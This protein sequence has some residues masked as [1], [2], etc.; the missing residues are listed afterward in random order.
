MRPARSIRRAPNPP[1]AGEG[2]QEDASRLAPRTYRQTS[3]DDGIPSSPMD[4]V[5]PALGTEGG[6]FAWDTERTQRMKMMEVQREKEGQ[7]G[8]LRNV[9]DMFARSSEK[10]EVKEERRVK[11]T[12]EGR[13]EELLIGN[14]NGE[15]GDVDSVLRKIQRDWPF[16]LDPE[17]APTSLALSLLSSSSTQTSHPPLR[18]F[19]TLHSTLSTALQRS[20]QRHYETYASSLPEHARL[21]EA[22]GRAQGLVKDTKKLLVVSRGLLG[23]DGDGGGSKMEMGLTWG[24]ERVVRDMLKMLDVM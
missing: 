5:S 20:V 17:F 18:E 13:E 16:V 4:V 9:V 7:E 2:Y 21:S 15:F 10:R 19:L 22:L 8:K 12:R 14:G 1:G 6:A 24:R 3:V 11:Q 23:G